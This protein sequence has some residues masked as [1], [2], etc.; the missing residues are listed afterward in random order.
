[1]VYTK[2]IH[3][4]IEFVGGASEIQLKMGEH[5]SRYIGGLKLEMFQCD[6]YIYLVL[7][8]QCLLKR[9]HEA[10]KLFRSQTHGY[11]HASIQYLLT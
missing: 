1:M 6:L 2:I 4:R 5:F 11:F 7:H 10:A 3:P 9:K 8:K